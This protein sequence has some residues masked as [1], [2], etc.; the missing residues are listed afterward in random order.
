MST[1]SSACTQVATGGIGESG[2]F[3]V[4]SHIVTGPTSK[5]MILRT[6]NTS[7]CPNTGAAAV[8]LVNGAPVASGVITALGSTIQHE[9][10]AGAIVMAIVHAIDLNNGVVCVRLGELEYALSECEL[11][12][13]SAGVQAASFTNGAASIP[14]RDW[15]AWN[16]LMPPRPDTF[17]VTGEVE[18]ANPGVN[19]LLVPRTPQGINP[20]ILLLDLVLAQQPGMWPQVVTW[21]PARYDKVNVTY[22]S[23]E[24]YYNN[25]VVVTVPVDN[26]Q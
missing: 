22:D 10:A 25:G 3:S 16:N 19:V 18:V 11:V 5:V 1:G 21:K 14:T 15:Y 4:V 20:R 6:V 23:V 2:R 26:V 8:L 9:V 12:R 13:K 17:H 7:L 24:V